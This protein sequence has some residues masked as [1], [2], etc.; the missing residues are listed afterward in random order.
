MS[1]EAFLEKFVKSF[2]EEYKGPFK[3]VKREC[4]KDNKDELPYNVTTYSYLLSYAS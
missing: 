2:N 3:I 4:N 1:R